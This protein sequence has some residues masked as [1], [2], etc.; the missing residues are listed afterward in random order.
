MREYLIDLFACPACH[1]RLKWAIHE[2]VGKESRTSDRAGEYSLVSAS[3][4]EIA[5]ADAVCSDCGASY[6]LRE[7]IAVFLTR[8]L[9][10]KDLWQEMDS[11]LSRYLREHPDID[12][13]LTQSPLEYLSPADKFFRG[14]ILSERK[15]FARAEEAYEAADREIYTGEYNKGFESQITHV[16]GTIGAECEKGLGREHSSVRNSPASDF[17]VDLASGKSALARRL[18]RTLA[19]RRIVVSDF[20]PLVLK[21]NKARFSHLG[22]SERAD[23]IAFDARRMPFKDSSIGTMT[24][25]VGLQCISDTGLA[26]KEI[27]RVLSGRMLAICLFNTEEDQKTRNV[28]REHGLEEMAYKDSAI[29]ALNAAGLTAEVQNS[30]LVRALPT[31]RSELIEGA[32][33]DAFPLRETVLEWCTLVISPIA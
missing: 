23:F 3:G 19:G 29:K 27:R 5:E 30:V 12:V 20:S 22:L 1:G 9:L 25:L 24:T 4:V 6:P 32:G 18:L 13:K 10:R 7:G 28:L 14:M 2:V 33:I 11:H 8:E 15:D 17:I 26:L 31:P 16:L 21:G